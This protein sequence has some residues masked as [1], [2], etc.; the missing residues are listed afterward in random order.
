MATLGSHLSL[1]IKMGT[2]TFIR[3][4]QF[5]SDSFLRN[6][7]KAKSAPKYREPL[8]AA[9]GNVS[10]APNALHTTLLL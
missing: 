1:R 7:P 8:R 4:S 5:L 3:A 2:E 6:R 9:A 10:I